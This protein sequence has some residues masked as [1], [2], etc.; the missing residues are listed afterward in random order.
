MAANDFA[1]QG[2]P[3]P[4]PNFAYEHCVRRTSPEQ[5][6]NL[7]LSTWRIASNGA[8]PIRKE[9]L[10]RFVEAFK[11]FGFRACAFIQLTD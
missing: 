10:E 9:T 1:L 7:D 8:E 4:R 11:P 5:Y 2:N 6:S 3:Q